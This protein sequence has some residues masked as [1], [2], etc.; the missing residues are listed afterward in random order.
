VEIAR[1]GHR[2]A[3]VATKNNAYSG[4]KAGPWH[5]DDDKDHILYL[6][7][8]LF[9][10]ALV[11]KVSVLVKGD[12]RRKTGVR[13]GSFHWFDWALIAVTLLT[14]AVALS[15][16][17]ADPDLWGHVQY[18]RDALAEG[19]S[20]TT[21][22]SY[23]AIGYRWINHENLAE[24]LLALGIDSVGPVGMLCL[25]CLLGVGVI[26]LI[27]LRARA[28]QVGLFSLCAVAML[29][30]VNLTYSWGMRPQVF[31]FVYYALLLSLLGWCFHGWEGGCHIPLFRGR[32]K[33]ASELDYSSRRM[34]FLWLAP[35]LFFFWANTHGGF[36]A[37][38]CIFVAYLLFRGVEVF[39]TR[40]SLAYG[41]LRRFVMMAVAGG[42]ATLVNP[43]G[44]R[45][46]L[47]LLESL[48]IPR[49]EIFEW[50]PPDLT[51]TIML[52]MW[53][54]TFTWIAV[55]LLSKRPRDLT[56]L[57]VMTIILWQAIEHSRH[58]PF[59]AIAFG[60]W[61]SPHVESVLR[62]FNV[63]SNM[64][65]F[66]VMRPGTKKLLAGALCL[67]VILPGYRLFDR[68]T[69]L[70]VKRSE[71]PVAAFQYTADRQLHGNMVITYNWAQYAIAAFGPRRGNDPGILVSF[72][73]RFRTCYP[74]EVVDM[75]FDFTLG[76][77]EP[78]FRGTDQKQL[79]DTRVLEFGAPDLVLINRRQPHSVNVMFRNRA[80]WILLYQDKIAQIWGRKTRYDN[81]SSIDYVAEEF[82]EIS[83]QE[84][85]G[86]VPWPAM[87]AR[88]HQHYL[89]AATEG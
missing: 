47:W 36:V 51:S 29:V 30:S 61:M 28:Q 12:K 34:R 24:I 79:D 21:T 89:L 69:N 50:R 88:Q 2:L 81:P 16:N 39:F 83:D 15:P 23:S 85:T 72:D 70:P 20:A 77:L 3:T 71:Y 19:L 7:S 49:P 84:Q 57:A 58:I 10:T 66:G 54:M 32:S 25:K 6:Q 1:R 86:S 44:P 40:G 17:G 26:G 5:A 64:S 4:F 68:L 60:F 52:P 74:Q 27:M 82:R 9:R 41:L 8:I 67:A 22:Y 11:N 87:P 35:V 14:C 55:L 75:N 65:D 43:Y 46:Q 45:L 42:L 13:T 76:D 53:L 33:N 73:G 59:F 18:G 37:G 63:A 80:R 78:R 38:Y 48:R 62:R 56:H 31:S